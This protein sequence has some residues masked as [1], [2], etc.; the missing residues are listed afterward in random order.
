MSLSV[1]LSML[2]LCQY[3]CSCLCTHL[4]VFVCVYICAIHVSISESGCVYVTALLKFISQ[5]A[6]QAVML[7][8][9]MFGFLT[10]PAHL[11]PHMLASST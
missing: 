2:P 10:L 3:M 7:S 1:C 5:L 9:M 8:C 11:V 4:A 6:V